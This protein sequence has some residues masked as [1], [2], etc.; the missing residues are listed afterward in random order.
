[1]YSSRNICCRSICTV[2]RPLTPSDSHGTIGVENA[3]PQIHPRDPT[4]LRLFVSL[5]S[6]DASVP[7]RRY[8]DLDVGV[9]SSRRRPTTSLSR[10][11]RAVNYSI[12]P[13]S[14]ASLRIWPLADCQ[15]LVGKFAS[16]VEMLG[17]VRRLLS[18]G[19]ATE[20]VMPTPTALGTASWAM[21]LQY[22]H[23]HGYP[24]SCRKS[25]LQYVRKYY[26]P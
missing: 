24:L 11:G 2:S 7:T 25:L 19:N 9:H 10:R 1:M 8:I 26:A 20:A 22:L 17:L 16:S 4:L 21:K 23:A 6:N 12:K 15:V 3:G 14:R 5:P 18:F 13:V